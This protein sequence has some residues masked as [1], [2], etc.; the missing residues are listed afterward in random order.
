[1]C[2]VGGEAG[3]AFPLSFDFSGRFGI[4]SDPKFAQ[5]LQAE[6]RP[7]RADPA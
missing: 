6:Q 3:A 7:E 4:R 1:M 5:F 2:V